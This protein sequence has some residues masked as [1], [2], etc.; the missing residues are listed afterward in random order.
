MTR[1][2]FWSARVTRAGTYRFTLEFAAADHDRTAYVRFGTTQASQPIRAG[3]SECVFESVTL[4][5]GDG[6]LEA[7][8]KS[9]LR[10]EMVEFLTAELR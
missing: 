10:S 2:P 4:P 5:V 1:L 6:R 3:M 8:L 7:W 9:G